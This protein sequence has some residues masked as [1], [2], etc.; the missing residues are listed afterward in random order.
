MIA[1]GFLVRTGTSSTARPAA[2]RRRSS[3]R[4][5]GARGAS[6]GAV[7]RRDGSGR[8]AAGY[9]LRNMTGLRAGG[10]YDLLASIVVLDH[11]IGRATS[12]RWSAWC[13]GRSTC[14]LARSPP[15]RRRRPRPRSRPALPPSTRSATAWPAPA[16]RRQATASCGGASAPPR[17]PSSSSV[18]QNAAGAQLGL[19]DRRRSANRRRQ[20]SRM[21]SAP[22]LPSSEASVPLLRGTPAVPRPSETEVGLLLGSTFE[23]E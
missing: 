10:A 22:R 8:P 14:R 21:A 7:L 20:R 19:L 1:D 12:S 17:P 15:A 3:S 5:A 9:T 4:R 2:R 23:R 13:L 16:S 6:H 18:K 11:A